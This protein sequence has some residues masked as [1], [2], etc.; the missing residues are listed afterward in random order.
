MGRAARLRNET[1]VREQL[2]DD[3]AAKVWRRGIERLVDQQHARRV[4]AVDLRAGM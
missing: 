3:K 1:G 2:P 4:R